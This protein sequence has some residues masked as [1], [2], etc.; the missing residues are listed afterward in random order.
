MNNMKPRAGRERT[1][2]LNE[3]FLD[4]EMLKAKARRISIQEGSAYSISEGAGIRYITPYA[5]ALGANNTHI[6]LL[7]SVPSLL[8]SLSELN[9]ADVMKKY[10]RKKIV[11]LFVSLQAAMWLV[12]I[13]I[14]A[15]YFIFHVDSSTA[16]ILLVIAY[17]L[18]IVFGMFPSP[19]WSSW[20]KDIIPERFGKYFG[21]RSAICSGVVL[22]SM[23]AA[24]YILDLFKM[25]SLFLGFSILFLLSFIGRSISAYLFT[26]KYEPEFKYNPEHKISFLSFVEEITKHN[27]SRSVL[28]VSSLNTMVAL[29]GP[30]FAVYMLKYLNLSYIEFTFVSMSSILITVLFMPAWGKFTDRYGNL[31]TMKITGF[32]IPLVPIV[33]LTTAFVIKANPG[34]IMPYIILIEAFSGFVW[35]GFNLAAGNFTYDAVSKENLVSFTAYSTIINNFGAFIGALVGGYITMLS[36]TFFGLN[37]LLFVF[38]LSGILRYA[39][40]FAMAP[41]IKEVRRVKNFDFHEAK[42]QFMHLSFG[43]LIRILR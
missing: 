4:E 17:T 7:N 29:A 21:K 28:F 15:L 40:Y 43:R 22:V 10:T 36:F 31:K 2:V 13:A 9:T 41:G 27:F 14:G 19:A 38:L 18:L 20:M 1:R 34:I 33:W 24:G 5:L 6:G 30:F 35:A 23:L 39:V 25:R 3:K 42:E 37:S 26:K 16:P 32:F 11:S 12:L 8:G